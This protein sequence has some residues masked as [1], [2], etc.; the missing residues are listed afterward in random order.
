MYTP[1]GGR[2]EV[3]E[4]RPCACKKP[5]N[6]RLIS[7]IEFLAGSSDYRSMATGAQRTYEG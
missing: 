2:G 7:K 4:A 6:R 5:I 1:D 3:H